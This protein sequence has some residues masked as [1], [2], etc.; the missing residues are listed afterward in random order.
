MEQLQNTPAKSRW[1][2]GLRVYASSF[3]GGG[4]LERGNLL[5]AG[6]GWSLDH[7]TKQFPMWWLRVK[8]KGKGTGVRNVL[9]WNLDHRTKQFPMCRVAWIIERSNFLCGGYASTRDYTSKLRLRV[10]V[11]L[12]FCRVAWIN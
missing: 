10:L 2:K 7:R 12:V 4:I 9:S 1:G 3:S 5:C 8:I 11:F 6:Y